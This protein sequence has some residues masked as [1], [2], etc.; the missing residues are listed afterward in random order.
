MKL[1]DFNE[2]FLNYFPTTLVSSKKPVVKLKKYLVFSRVGSYYCINFLQYFKLLQLLVF[3]LQSALSSNSNITFFFDNKHM[4]A[5]YQEISRESNT[6]CA[7][8]PRAFR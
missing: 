3:F 2:Y 6:F 5:M 4:S 7:Y 8:T 1:Q